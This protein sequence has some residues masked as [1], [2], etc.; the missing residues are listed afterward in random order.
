MHSAPTDPSRF[1]SVRRLLSVASHLV[2]G[3]GVLIGILESFAWAGPAPIPP[4]RG[5]ATD[6]VSVSDSAPWPPTTLNQILGGWSF[7]NVNSASGL[8]DEAW[9]V[10][11][12]VLVPWNKGLSLRLNSPGAAAIRYSVRQANTNGDFSVRNGSAAFWFRPDWTS[13]SSRAPAMA[14]PLLEV[15][16]NRPD[17]IGWW[18]WQVAPGGQEMTFVSQAAGQQSSMLRTPVA[19]ASNSWKHVAMTWSPTNSALFLDGRLVTNGLGVTRWPA[20]AE[21][22]RWGWGLGGD[23]TGSLQIRGD[24]DTLLT[25]N[26]PLSPAGV[27]RLASMSGGASGGGLAEYNLAE[28]LNGTDPGGAPTGLWIQPQPST[29]TRRGWLQGTFVGLAYE[30]FGAE[31]VAGPWRLEQRFNGLAGKTWFELPAD[32]RSTLILVAASFADTDADGLSDE[33]E[34]RISGT[35]PNNA[36]TDQDG[37]PDGWE[38][39]YG[40]NP[41]SATDEVSDRDGDGFPNEMGYRL[42]RNPLVAEG[43]SLVSVSASVAVATEA[44]TGTR[45]VIRRTA[46]TSGA[47]QVFF[48]L[49]GGAANGADYT[50]IPNRVT[51][52][53]GAIEVMVPVKFI[54]D[55]LDEVGETLTLDLVTGAEYGLAT[56]RSATMTLTDNDLPVVSIQAT[57]PEAREPRFTWTDPGE[58]EVRRDGLIGQALTVLLKR[59]GT[60]VAG[61]DDVGTPASVVIPAGEV[62]VKIPVI[63]L[64]NQKTGGRAVTVEILSAATYSIAGAAHKATV[65]IEDMQ[66]PEV[67]VVAQ[68][69][70]AGEKLTPTAAANPG[71]FRFSRTGSTTKALTIRYRVGG[72]ATANSSD[73]E[74]ADYPSLPGVVI[75]PAGKVDQDVSVQPYE[76]IHVEAMETII[77]ALGGSLDYAIGN[78]SEATVTVNDNSLPRC[79]SRVIAACSGMASGPFAQIEITRLGNASGT[80]TVPLEVRGRRL[81]NSVW[82]DFKN[83]PLNVGASYGLY[84]DGQPAISVVFPKG[85][86]R[87]VISVKAMHPTSAVPNATLV[88]DP[89]G[90]KQEHL[91]KFIDAE[92]QV[93]I[94]TVATDVVEGSAWVV[95]IIPGSSTSGLD[96]TTVRLSVSG[97]VNLEDYKVNGAVVEGNDLVVNIPPMVP[98][99][100]NRQALLTITPKADNIVETPSEFMAL[101][102]HQTQTGSGL[103]SSQQTKPYWASRFL[104]TRESKGVPFDVDG[105][106]FPDDYEFSMGTDPLKTTEL[107]RDTDRDGLGD[108]EEFIRGTKYDQADTD[109]DGLSD[110]VEGMLALDP[111]K[112]DS[113]KVGLE[114]DLVPIRLRTGG[115]FREANG[116]CFRCHAPGMKVGDIALTDETADS[117]S[118]A[119]GVMERVVLLRAGTTHEISLI[120]PRNYVTT[121][122][123]A[124]DAEILPVAAGGIPGFV[125]LDNS[126]PL[127][128]KSKPYSAD[129][130]TRKATL[131]VLAP[132]RLAVDADRD[133]EI[134]FDLS[135]ATTTSRPFRFWVNNDSDV[136]AVEILTATADYLGGK[137]QGLRDLEDFARLWISLDGL[138]DLWSQPGFRV[139]LEWRNVTAGQPAIHIYP[140]GAWQS[141]GVQYLST[142]EGAED[143]LGQV[144]LS[145][146]V[147]IADERTGQYI[148]KPGLRLVLPPP[149]TSR[150]NGSHRY[151]IFEGAAVGQ[152]ELVA[153]VL[154]DGQVVSESRPLHLRLMDVKQMYQRAQAGPVDGFKPPYDFPD[155]EPPAIHAGYAPWRPEHE[156]EPSPTESPLAAIFVHGWNMKELE[157]VNFAE[158]MFKRLWQAGFTG[159]FAAFRWPTHTFTEPTIMDSFNVSEHR[160]FEYGASLKAFAE[161][162]PSAYSRNFIGHSMG[163]V[164]IASALRQGLT[165]RN[166]LMMQAAISA[167]AFD[168]RSTLNWGPLVAGEASA[169]P[170]FRTPDVFVSDRG[171]RG[172]MG[173]KTATVFN[174]FNQDDYALQTG[175]FI[176]NVE[177][178]WIGNQLYQK[179]HWRNMSDYR[180]YSWQPMA[181]KVPF[182]TR[183][184]Y[185]FEKRPERVVR[186]VTQVNEGLAFIARSRTRALGAESRA[187]GWTQVGQTRDLG[188]QPHG[189]RETRTDHSGQFNRSIQ[190]VWALHKI[191][192]T[193]IIK[194]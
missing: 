58:L 111:L 122:K 17:R 154:R 145:N 96:G 93:A 45:F 180:R 124:Y 141:G 186:F 143:Q 12:A 142:Q 113:E 72:S 14:T 121:T 6:G 81:V 62:A 115:S 156:F 73:Y 193:D 155:Q 183:M 61:T 114:E 105:D 182:D 90:L 64:N 42:G 25:F 126:K 49:R 1:S 128:G 175:K 112:K 110:F 43:V 189:F 98:G 47:L 40:L 48:E 177:A 165:A 125:V 33:Y 24:Y 8:S 129:M 44:T 188:A 172:L 23:G 54:D 59:V 149:V 18:A 26:Y 15:G 107:L 181:P 92:D 55:S 51:I 185:A 152:G 83:V 86:T 167:G 11:N 95:S 31:Q 67:S 75:I 157:A 130:F 19:F 131:R 37:M 169:A 104:D 32:A 176:L 178:N 139:A 22:E 30:L 20:L 173:E 123:E 133:G 117:G 89:V 2:L 144:I 162:L 39:N 140:A 85:V 53:A 27:G 16:A 148:L 160:A 63:P 150:F 77:V 134:R 21:R 29:T 68:D 71:T 5:W 184:R 38:V 103:N 97:T 94:T 163:G 109:G 74:E 179:P 99:A 151:L 174:Y 28:N 187:L 161:T 65:A 34:R 69:P 82:Y 3:C 60:A 136:G 80:Y 118:E 147:A 171:Y 190:Q 164:V 70:E 36:D 87:R 7:D 159:R 41:R 4:E 137:I 120:P 66:P 78:A 116:S 106:K 35:L 91:I 119:G 88:I 194:K 192:L 108:R 153:M 100:N 132:P 56:A 127:L 138:N 135:D 79:S 84:V 57:D 170:G 10:T 158:T 146:K 191:I 101:T 168:A 76:D 166:V 102:Y 50:W 46:P 52:P 13:G 9:W